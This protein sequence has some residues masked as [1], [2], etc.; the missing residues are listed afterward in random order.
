MP[1]SG[2]VALRDATPADE[3]RA[4]GESVI[5]RVCG[6]SAKTVNGVP[7]WTCRTHVRRVLGA[8]RFAPARGRR[9]HR[10][11]QLRSR[12]SA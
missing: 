9:R 1:Q 4:R 11:H 8:G 12:W 7:R 6:S 2:T 10:M 5:V 3:D